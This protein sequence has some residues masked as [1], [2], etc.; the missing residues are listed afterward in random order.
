MSEDNDSIPAKD[1]V[2]L[3]I[4]IE[5]DANNLLEPESTD[6]FTLKNNTALRNFKI[7]IKKIEKFFKTQNH[8]FSRNFRDLNS[9][10]N[11]FYGLID[12]FDNHMRL[13]NFSMPININ[14]QSAKDKE[15][16]KN[17]DL[18]NKD[19]DEMK[20]YLRSIVESADKEQ[21][22]K[23]EEIKLNDSEFLQKISTH[24]Q[25]VE[26]FMRIKEA[27]DDPKKQE[28]IRKEITMNAN[29]SPD[30]FIIE[31]API[32]GKVRKW[33]YKPFAK[34][35]ALKEL[36]ESQ[37][38][39]PNNLDLQIDIIQ[40]FVTE[41]AEYGTLREYYEKNNPDITI[42]ARLALEIARGLNYLE[43][44][45]IFHHD[46]RSANVLVDC[47]EHAKIINFELSRNFS[48]AISKSIEISMEIF[49]MLLWELA[50]QKLPF[51]ESGLT[52]LA[53]SQLI[54]DGAMN[55][56]FSSYDVPKKMEKTSTQNKAKDRPEMKEVLRKIRIINESINTTI[57]DASESYNNLP[58]LSLKA[59]EQ[60]KLKN[61]S[62]K[63]AWETIAKYSEIDNDFTAKY[64]KGH[65]LYHKVINFPYSDNERMQLA[66]EAFKEAAD[67]ANLQDAQYMY[68]SCIYKKDLYKAIEYFEKAADQ[69]HTVAMHNLGLLYY[70]GKHIDVDKKKGEYWFKRAVAGNL[71]ASIEFCKKNGITF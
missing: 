54:L 26:D 30:N 59:I 64:W 11:E 63:R 55:L 3:L 58:M 49:G 43:E 1:F 38:N 69:N 35:V 18:V 51:S 53:I 23:I 37:K 40:Y 19:T 15:S 71:D 61:G 65:Y 41:W 13:L 57:P 24:I 29:L 5:V 48:V 50:E 4:D 62:K 36:L 44:Y 25:N 34:D 22:N 68:A 60:T 31:E 39:K 16:A 14:Q 12:E 7:I 56:K 67:G 32:R 42:R 52:V 46:V 70:L 45:E 8:N 20:E 33:H 9:I 21:I 66:A 47:F 6:F 27:F 28:L 10:K 17:I 2:S